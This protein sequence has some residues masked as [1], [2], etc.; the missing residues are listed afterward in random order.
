MFGSCAG[1]DLRGGVPWAS[2]CMFGR[3]GYMPCMLTSGSLPWPAP[4]GW[5]HDCEPVPCGVSTRRCCVWVIR[6]ESGEGGGRLATAVPFVQRWRWSLMLLGCIHRLSAS[7]ACS[8]QFESAHAWYWKA[9]KLP[10]SEFVVRF[11]SIVVRTG[12]VLLLLSVSNTALPQQN[13]GCAHSSSTPPPTYLAVVW[14]GT[15]VQA[16]QTQ[17]RCLAVCWAVAPPTPVHTAPI[18]Q[19]HQPHTCAVSAVFI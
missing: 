16:S 4:T 7:H 9:L 15:L 14:A 19:Q 12:C 11:S 2:I 10:T 8:Q 5:G 17:G 1:H 3:K 6:G 18:S 13:V